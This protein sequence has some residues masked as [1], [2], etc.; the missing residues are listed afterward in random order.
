MFEGLNS[1]CNVF[2]W[3]V[4]QWLSGYDLPKGWNQRESNSGY[5]L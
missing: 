3:Y 1:D 5:K 4:A 2:D